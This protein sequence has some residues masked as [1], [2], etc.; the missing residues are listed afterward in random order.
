MTFTSFYFGMDGSSSTPFPCT[1]SGH[2]FYIG[3]V[4]GEVTES[5]AEFNV[6][7]AQAATPA[8]TSAYWD[9]GGSTSIP[10]GL[11]ASQWGQ[12]QA[13]AFITAIATG[14]NAIHIQGKTLFCDIEAGNPGW[15]ESDPALNR[16]ILNGFLDGIATL[17]FVPGV[18]ANLSD[19][20]RYLGASW[21]ATT[22]FVWWLADWYVALKTCQ[23]AETNF[24]N[25]F[26][27]NDTYSRGGYKVMIWQYNGTQGGS[28]RDLNVTPYNGYLNGHWNPTPAG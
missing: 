20:D 19:F 27:G 2:S 4:G 21:I 1:G 5:S 7:T 8:F 22:P 23:E 16:E 10:V 25:F 18:Y 26:A 12:K 3:R 15:A 13:E 11:T 28:P 24:N 6:A 17:G 14:P 9:L